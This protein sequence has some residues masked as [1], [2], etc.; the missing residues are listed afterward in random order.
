MPKR[1]G[2][3][4]RWV[5]GD[6][7]LFWLKEL[8]PVL[9]LAVAL[10]LQR[11][12]QQADA[13]NYPHELWL[14]LG[15]FGLAA[16]ALTAVY[17]F[18]LRH[19]AARLLAAVAALYALTMD[20]DVR[21]Q[22]GAGLAGVIL[23]GAGPLIVT[24][25]ILAAAWGLGRLVEWL[26]GRWGWWQSA[27][28]VTMLRL[29]LLGVFVTNLLLFLQYEGRLSGVTAYSPKTSVAPQ[30]APTAK[31][32]VYY[33]VLD[34]YANSETLA[35]YYGFDNS[36]FLNYLRD[37][38]WVVRDPAYSN[39]Q[40]TAQSIA[41]TMR[42][43]YHTDIQKQLK[44]EPTISYLPYRK[45]LEHSPVSQWFA[46]NGYEVHRL[47]SWYG[48]TRTDEY[49]QSRNEQFSLTLFNQTFLLS[50]LQSAALDHTV[51]ASWFR[52]GVQVGPFTLASM[53]RHDTGQQV[54]DQ[55]DELSELAAEPHD[56]PRF[57][58][59]HIL[60]PHP[61]YVF[62][63]DGT[64]PS[65]SVDDNN[66]GAS[67]EL[68]YINQLTYLNDRIKETVAAIRKS[69]KE[70][71]VIIIQ[72]DE[73]PYPPAFADYNNG[74]ASLYPWS[75]AS[76]ETLKRKYGVLAAYYLPGVPAE[77]TSELNSS[78]NTFRFVFNHYFGAKLPYLPDCSL[79][80]DGGRPFAF[81]DVT[82]KIQGSAASTACQSYASKGVLK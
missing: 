32:D 49:G 60:S 30:L 34:R 23:P 15:L 58:F 17:H 4:P 43:D 50:D 53:G 78:V 72:S 38:G 62:T 11:Y 35:K 80:Y 74:E 2:W 37:D 29:V 21:L 3:W 47:A 73:G 31:R 67:R 7:R 33:L 20:F 52:S 13:Y 9:L 18:A 45:L 16:V 48:V 57:V 1:P 81:Y 25:V 71:P 6:S 54:L 65:Y 59:A 5:K 24:V 42:M 64:M 55:L 56:Q 8:P 44:D 12:F 76:A 41:S 27:S 39:Y 68:K 66:Q 22:A 82:A 51:F 28:P 75:K 10:P 61:P 77:Q 70:E 36:Q 63:P 14:L 40:F 79:L 69:S 19:P 26:A 46:G